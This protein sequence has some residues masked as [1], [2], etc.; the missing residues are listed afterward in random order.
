MGVVSLSDN[1]TNLEEGWLSTSLSPQRVCGV[2]GA[3]NTWSSF[4]RK[5]PTNVLAQL[6]LMEVAPRVDT[7]RKTT[8]AIL[9]ELE[10]SGTSAVYKQARTTLTQWAQ[11]LVLEL[12]GGPRGDAPRI[13]R[14]LH[15]LRLVVRGLLDLSACA[16]T[17]LLLLSCRSC[18]ASRALQSI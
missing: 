2:C 1:E 6:R 18:L 10:A 13:A 7:T 4:E 3:L 8:L 16:L 5:P 9:E 15:L 12:L 17:P 14:A 11:Q